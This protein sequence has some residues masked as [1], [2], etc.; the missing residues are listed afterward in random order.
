[1]KS[2]KFD[3]SEFKALS[4]SQLEAIF[5]LRQNVFIIEQQCFYEDIDGSDQVASH[6]LLQLNDELAG[7][8]RIFKPGIKY[9][10]AASLGRIVVQKNYRGTKIGKLLISKGIEIVRLNYPNSKIKIEAQAALENYYS[11]FGFI[12]ISD[13]YEVDQI[14]HVLMEMKG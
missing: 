10:N 3:H 13:V 8:L 9:E 4:S 11:E 7:Y 12:T 1:M 14:P 5:R 6:L 2:I